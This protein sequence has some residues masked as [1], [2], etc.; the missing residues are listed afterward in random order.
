MFFKYRDSML[1]E[2]LV[3]IYTCFLKKTNTSFF[4]LFVFYLFVFFLFIIQLTKA[5]KACN[6]SLLYSFSILSFFF[7]LLYNYYFFNFFFSGLLYN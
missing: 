2:I 1:K 3:H 7:L 4:N 5:K 6:T